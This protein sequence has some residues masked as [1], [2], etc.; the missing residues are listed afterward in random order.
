MK[1]E[2]KTCLVLY[3]VAAGKP[4]EE[5]A[6]ADFESI[7]NARS[8]IKA[9]KQSLKELG[10][11][12]RTLA[13]RKLSSKFTAQLEEIKP[14]L[15]FNLC[16]TLYNHKH[17][18]LAEMYVAAWIELL[19]I[20]YTGS[21]PLSLVLALNKMRCKQLCRAAGLPVTPSILVH[22]GDKV[23]LDPITPPFIVKPVRED[24]S[25]GITKDSVVKTPKEAEEQVAVIHEQYKQAA[26]VE[27]YI[28]GRE[29]TVPVFGNPPRVLG[30][31]EIDFSV[32]PVQEPKI[33]S[34][35][36]KW[37]AKA[38]DLNAVFP[39]ELE[40][41]L[42]NRLE[43]LAIK[44]FQTLGCR[45]YARIDFRISENRRPFVLEINPNPDFSPDGE[46]GD[47]AKLQNLTYTDLVREI[48]ENTLTRKNE[49]DFE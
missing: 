34:Y 22:P 27:E 7:L 18:A 47:A 4:P 8:D 14:D 41:T 13:L 9:V 29:V 45:D 31:G 15:I 30:I 44:A 49:L 36:A 5:M 33:K 35:E 10:M 25:F 48:V 12:V 26:L 23:N 21:P 46:F 40:T 19:K 16:E 39:A 42:K 43:R 38:P 6:E 32:L 17:K 2:E 1:L 28:E 20:P 24:G 3:N 37:D 11:N